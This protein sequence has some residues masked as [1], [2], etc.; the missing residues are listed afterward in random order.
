M[1]ALIPVLVE[2]GYRIATIKHH[3]HAGTEIDQPGKD[4][5]RHAKAGADVVVV[6]GPDV[7]GTFE[8]LENELP[9]E[10]IACRV[11]MTTSVDLILTEG[12]KR[13]SAVKIEV[14]RTA[15]SDEVICSTDE[16][17][18]FVSDVPPD[19]LPQGPPVIAL[20]GVVEAADLVE[21]YLVRNRARR[22]G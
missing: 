7:M 1:E 16:V 3:S 17:L 10:E 19:K 15:R 6:A 12:Y 2:R 22:A 20:N 8:R 13:G 18:A 14:V 4:T 5:W 11:A 21:S 9:L